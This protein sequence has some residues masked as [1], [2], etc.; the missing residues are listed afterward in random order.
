MSQDVVT[1]IV[2][3]GALVLL[4]LVLHGLSQKIDKLIVMTENI[5]MR[6][7]SIVDEENNKGAE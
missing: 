3:G 2:Q 6:L 5:V 7:L 1:G 4:A